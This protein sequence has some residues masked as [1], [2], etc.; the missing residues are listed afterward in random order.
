[1]AEALLKKVT[2]KDAPFASDQPLHFIIASGRLDW[3][4]A[5]L[6]EALSTQL[7]ERC[8]KELVDLLSD[9][10]ERWWGNS[11]IVY[12]FAE[13][14]KWRE[15]SAFTDRT[16]SLLN[17]LNGMDVSVIA[18]L[19]ET[20]LS[21]EHPLNACWLHKMLLNRSMAERDA[22]WSLPL[23]KKAY[24]EE[25]HPSHRLIT[26]AMYAPKD[27]ATSKTIFCAR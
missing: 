22:L 6:V 25:G 20:S 4:W 16:L 1:M 7:P 15:P 19:L 26:W 13:S 9:G 3:S 12:G 17:E 27:H 14:V 24:S 23:A 10:L 2:K 11:A 18:L 21:A 8:E 5:G